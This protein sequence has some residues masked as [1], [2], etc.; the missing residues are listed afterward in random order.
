EPVLLFHERLHRGVFSGRSAGAWG[1]PLFR[2]TVPPGGR[3]ADAA[4]PAP[5]LRL[6][7]HRR[8]VKE[9]RTMAAQEEAAPA[10]PTSWFKAVLGTL[11]G[12]LSGAL[13]MYLTPF[14]DRVVKPAK[15]VANFSYQADG[16]KVRF[17][18][19]AKS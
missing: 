3:R 16:C 1:A 14:V 7:R 2:Q 5:G 18:N 8:V 13:V 9:D 12:L 6:R 10:K 11:G 4:P 17:Q 19:L 15:P